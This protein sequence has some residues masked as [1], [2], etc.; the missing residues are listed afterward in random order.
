MTGR[1]RDADRADSGFTLAEVLIAVVLS[2]MLVSGVVGALA[3]SFNVFNNSVATIAESSDADVIATLLIQDAQSAGGIDVTTA[4]TDPSLGISLTDDGGCTAAGTLVVRF[5]WLDA[6][7]RGRRVATYARTPANAL[8]RRSCVS[9]RPPS[10]AIVGSAVSSAIATCTPVANCTG[11]PTGI[12]LA[13]LG[14][15]QNPSSYTVKATTRSRP[16]VRSAP[17]APTVAFSVFG[18]SRN[19]ECPS[20]DLA[21]RAMVTVVGE[22]VAASTACRNGPIGGTPANLRAT[23]IRTV[24]D[25]ADPLADLPPPVANCSGAAADPTPVGRN[26]GSPTVYRRRITIGSDTVFDPGDYVFCNGINLQRGAKLSGN[27]VLLYLAGSSS[28]LRGVL[29]LTPPSF[30]PRAN[31]AIWASSSR[32]TISGGQEASLIRGIVYSPTEE[33]RFDLD[34]PINVA[35]IVASEIRFDETGSIRIGPVPTLIVLPGSLPVGTQGIAYPDTRMSAT[36]GTAPYTWYGDGLPRG[37][38][39]DVATGL[40]SGTPTSTGSSTVTITAVDP[41]G[42]AVS[43]RLVLTVN[44]PPQIADVVLPNWTIDRSL[45]TLPLVATNGTPPYSWSASGLPPGVAM[46]ATT[47][48][49]VGTPTLAGAY[50]LDVQVTDAVLVAARR[51]F[52]I[53]INAAPTVPAPTISLR[54]NRRFSNVP[55][56]VGGTPAHTWYPV[57]LPSFVTLNPD[58]TIS[59]RAPGG[60]QQVVFTIGVIDAAGAIVD[61]TVITLDIT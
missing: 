13:L 23:T 9:G 18:D 32:T 5:S 54:Q 49:L 38:A 42:A 28:E 26:A 10:D 1:R 56:V 33:L 40:I 53:T 52:T 20:I 17:S 3:T 59:G 14:S 21:R 24:A 16:Q 27:G 29:D 43:A 55:V 51:T 7:D 47:G 57:D 4:D 35:A 37:L 30:G 48:A 50:T 25:L 36:G 41:T 19:P 34:R 11:S 15:G 45:V 61:A 46:D 2:G 58:G 12:S 39:I 8:V 60:A 31:V 44:S 6:V 22:L